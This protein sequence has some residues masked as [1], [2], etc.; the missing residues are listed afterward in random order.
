MSEVSQV[1]M[2]AIWRAQALLAGARGYGQWTVIP[3]I[4]H[5]A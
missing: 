3:H 1:G 4:Y 5:G 2:G